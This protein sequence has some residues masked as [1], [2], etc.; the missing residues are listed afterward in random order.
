MR[1]RM[2]RWLT[3]RL[4]GFALGSAILLLILGSIDCGGAGPGPS[5]VRVGSSLIGERTVEH[6]TTVI[7]RGA[8]VANVAAPELSSR[9]QAVALLISAYQLI[10]EASSVDLR[11]PHAQIAQTVEQQERSMPGGPSEFK[12]LLS[13]S[14]ETRADVEFEARAH[15]AASALA[16]RLTALVERRSKAQVTSGAV[17][18]FYRAHAT[19]YHL[20]ERRYYDLIERIPSKA[21][22]TALAK[23]VGT[24]RR[25]SERASKERPFRP[26]TF[27]GLPG[28]GVV[29]RAVFAAKVGVLTGPLPLQGAYA[30]FVL[31]RIDPARVQPLAEVRRLIERRL[32]TAAERRTRALAIKDF[33]RRW[34]ARTDCKLGYVVQKCKQY[35]GPDTPERDPFAG[36]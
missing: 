9:Q 12:E 36:Y 29:Y 10:E 21:A 30:L 19:R 28:Q 13:T 15:W 8:I 22:A 5:V 18:R 6:W 31:R 17:A 3:S 4:L 20:R 26:A 14:G 16:R 7:T 2:W 11:P 1:A 32:L 35:V 24:G 27:A 23:R 33:R 34:V 25:F